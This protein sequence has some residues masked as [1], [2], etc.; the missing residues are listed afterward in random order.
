MLDARWVCESVSGLS[1]LSGHGYERSGGLVGVTRIMR[2]MDTNGVTC[3]HVLKYTRE[4]VGSCSTST[5]IHLLAP[6]PVSLASSPCRSFNPRILPG[7]HKCNSYCR[8]R[9]RGGG[10]GG[11]EGRERRVNNETKLLW[12]YILPYAYACPI[13]ICSTSTCI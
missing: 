8:N 13:P 3:S 9:S 1:M 7:K 2:I 6:C 4:V 12:R 10:E 11:R 5:S